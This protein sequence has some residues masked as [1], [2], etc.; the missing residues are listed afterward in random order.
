MEA[1]DNELLSLIRED[2][3]QAAN[4][5]IDRYRPYVLNLARQKVEPEY[6]EDIT[7]DILLKVFVSIKKFEQRSLLSTWIYRIAVNHL[8][9]HK[10]SSARLL[11][12]PNKV[13]Y[14]MA[15]AS[16]ENELL[17]ERKEAMLLGMTLC[18]DA[19]QRMVI[20]L[21]DIFKLDHNVASVIMNTTPVNFRKRLSR[22]RKELKYFINNQCSLLNSKGT[23]R[24]KFKSRSY[25]EKG[26]ISKTTLTFSKEHIQSAKRLIAVCEK[27]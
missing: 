1:S 4:I 15:S 5:L 24:C 8:L 14:R 16:D 7:Q 12:H 26:W 2:H 13:Q 11:D 19:E 17:K 22:T 10:G 3:V 21:A 27:K 20:T 9:R 25:M 23:C 18:M 6:V